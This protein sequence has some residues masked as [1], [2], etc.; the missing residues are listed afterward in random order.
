MPSNST[1]ATKNSFSSYQRNPLNLTKKRK[2]QEGS[3][4]SVNTTNEN[5]ESKKT[6]S[7]NVQMSTG[8]EELEIPSTQESPT[9]YDNIMQK[10]RILIIEDD[11]IEEIAQ[12][13]SPENQDHNLG[14]KPR[15]W[16]QMSCQIQS[17]AC[18]CCNYTFYM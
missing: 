13:N 11:Q 7:A 12:E 3:F 14:Q 6:C 15:N 5:K 18:N 4:N 9:Q 1:Q 17:F 2:F 10:M 8:V 16:W